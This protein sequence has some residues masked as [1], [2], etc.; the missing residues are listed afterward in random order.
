MGVGLE[1]ADALMSRQGEPALVCRAISCILQ[2]EGR[3]ILFS[4]NR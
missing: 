2:S 1:N 3:V 4:L